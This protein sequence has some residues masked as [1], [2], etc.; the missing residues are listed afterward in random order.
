[1]GKAKGK[2][3]LALLALAFAAILAAVLCMNFP[4][5]EVHAETAVA[6]VTAATGETQTYEK[7][8]DAFKAAK[9]GDT[10]DILQDASE[11][12][13]ADLAYG[14]EAEGG[15]WMYIRDKSLTING[16]GHTLTSNTAAWA[17]YVIDADDTMDTLTINDLTIVSKVQKIQHPNTDLRGA[18]IVLFHG[19]ATLKLNN[20]TLD[21]TATGVGNMAPLRVAGNG[22]NNIINIS[23][24]RLLANKNNGYAMIAFNPVDLTVDN[25]TLSGWSAL[26]MTGTAKGTALGTAG[27][28]VIIQ[29]GSTLTTQSVHNDSSINM[30]G[31]LAFED[32]NITVDIKD[33]KITADCTGNAPQYV[34]Y[35]SNFDKQSRTGIEVN[36]ANTDVAIT[37]EQMN[38]VGGYGAPS[39]KEQDVEVAGGN[40]N[41][42]VNEDY[43]A[44][45]YA[46]NEDGYVL[47]SDMQDA[48]AK[49]EKGDGA[50]SYYNDLQAAFTAAAGGETVKLLVNLYLTETVR[51]E[52]GNNTVFD[53]NG[54]KITVYKDESSGKSLY[55]FD[56]YG[57][58]TLMDSAGTGSITARGIQNLGDGVLTVNSG[59][60]ISCDS[61]GGAAIWNE[62]TAYINGGEF[63]TVFVGTPGDKV[64]IGCLNNSGTA[65]VTGGTFNDVNRR[66]YAII[67]TGKIEITP[68]E[69]KEVTVF[70]AHGALAVDSGTAV[71]NG[72]NYSS[73]EYY[74]LYVSNDGLGE[75]PLEAAVT[76]NGGTFSGK[77]YSVWVGSD[78]N[79]PV[80]STI[81][82]T[83]GVFKKPLNAQD[84]ARDG[85]IA[86]S[87]GTF[88]EA[89]PEEYLAEGI[90][91][92]TDEE[93]NFIADKVENF[94]DAVAMVEETGVAYETLQAAVDAAV[95]G[96]VITV[97]K[98]ITT[99]SALIKNTTKAPLAAEITIDLNGKT[100]TATG[101]GYYLFELIPTTSLTIT[102]SNGNA[103]VVANQAMQIRAYD[104][105]TVDILVENI[106]F[107]GTITGNSAIYLNKYG[108][109]EKQNV[110]LNNVTAV[111][112]NNVGA[113]IKGVVEATGGTHLTV[114]D[115]RIEVT[116]VAAERSRPFIGVYLNNTASTTRGTASSAVIENSTVIANKA[117]G[118][119]EGSQWGVGIG[120]YT[121][122]L[123]VSGGTVT[124]TDGAG[125]TFFGGV[126]IDSAAELLDA[127]N[128]ESFKTLNLEGGVAVSG[129]TFA[130]SGNG[131]STEANSGTVI[132]V[133]SATL[134]GELGVGIYQPQVG[135]LNINAG[136]NIQGS[137]GIEIRA[138]ELNV[139]G[140]NITATWEKL[141]TYP[142]QA[143][144]GTSID[145]A[146]IA[147][148]Q[149]STNKPIFVNIIDGNFTG[150]VALYE[151]DL[152]NEVANEQI[153]ADITGGTFTSTQADMPAVSS[154][155]MD[156]FVLGGKFN[157]ALEAK[158]LA[159]GSVL[160]ATE[161]E[162]G[163]IVYEVQAED[164]Y[165]AVVT[166]GEISIAYATLEEAVNAAPDGSTIELLGDV[167]LTHDIR[168][169]KDEVRNLTFDLGGNTLTSE[170]NI[171][172][173]Y[174]YGGTVTFGNGTIVVTG[175]DGT[176]GYA[177]DVDGMYQAAKLVLES[178]LTVNVQT[179]G[180]HDSAVTVWGPNATLVTSA[181]LTSTGNEGTITGNGTYSGTT[182]EI[183]GGKVINKVNTA[184]YHPQNGTLTV[185]DAYIEGVTGI[186]MRAGELTVSGNAE[187]VATGEFSV[188]ANPSGGTLT[189]VAIGISQ[190]STNLPITVNLEGGTYTSEN[191]Y[192]LYETDVQDPSAGDIAAISITAG[193][194]A[195]KIYSENAEGFIEGTGVTFSEA[196]DYSYF[197]EDV[198]AVAGDEGYVTESGSYTAYIE[199][200]GVRV[201]Y[202]SLQQAVNAIP[203]GNTEPVTVYIVD[204]DG[205]G[206]VEG[207]GVKVG[208][209]SGD[210]KNVI[211][212]FGDL[213]YTVIN[214]TVGS[215]GTETNG[216][217]LLRGSKVVMQ[218]GT[219]KAGTDAAAILIQKYCDLELID[220]TID[221][222]GSN[223]QYAVS[224]NNGTTTFKGETNVYAREGWFAFDVCAWS[225]YGDVAVV[226]DESFTGSVQGKVEYS[227]Y[228]SVPAGWEDKLQITF[229]EGNQGLYDLTFSYGA[230]CDMDSVNI[231]VYD[232][233]FVNAVDAAYLADGLLLTVDEDGNYVVKN[234]DTVAAEGYK[235]VSDNGETRI[236]YE[237]IAEALAAADGTEATITLLDNV[238]EN[239]TIAKGQSIVLDLNGYTLTNN[240]NAHTIY[241]QGKL[242]IVGNGTVDNIN[243][244]RAALV[245]YGT[246]ELNGGKFTRSKED[247]SSNSWYVILN[248][249]TMTV[250]EG[251]SVY[252][253]QSA[254][255][256]SSLLVNGLEGNS[257][258][259]LPSGKD[260]AF[261]T[262]NGG[263]FMGGVAAIKNDYYGILD[264]TGGT[265][266]GSSTDTALQNWGEA[267]ITGDAVFEQDVMAYTQGSSY[268]K[269]NTSISGGTFLGEI[270]SRVY[271]D[272]SSEN[273][274]VVYDKDNVAVS[275]GTF[276]E[277]VPAAYL[278]DGF[279]LTVGDGTYGVEEADELATVTRG[280]AVYN[281][282]TLAEALAFAEDG[283]TVTLL[284]GGGISEAL[285]IDKDIT[286]DLNGVT[287]YVNG[288]QGIVITADGVTVT[289]GGGSIIASME[290]RT[291]V[292]IDG[293]KDVLLENVT[294]E[295]NVVA[296]GAENG[297]DVTLQNST[298]D[299]KVLTNSGSANAI[300]I[301][302][303]DME[304]IDSV[305][306][307]VAEPTTLTGTVCTAI[308]IEGTYGSDR[309]AAAAADPATYSHLKISGNNTKITARAYAIVGNG[310]LHGTDIDI[311]GGTIESTN[312]IAIYHPQVGELTISG[313]T[314]IK[315][316]S[317]L[318]MRAGSLV[319]EGDGVSVTATDPFM[320]SPLSDGFRFAGVAV[321][322]SRYF[323]EEETG[324]SVSIEGGTFT[325]TNEEG[326]AFYEK[327]DE[328]HAPAVT[329]DNQDN[330]S[331]SIAG[332]TFEGKVESTNVTGFI[333]GGMFKYRPAEDYMNPDFVAELQ[334]GYYVPVESSALRA[335]Q[336]NAQADVREY[337]AMLG[338]KWA[339]VLELEGEGDEN[340]VALVAAYN[341]IA[342]T[343]SEKGV[344]KARLDA[345]DAA[346]TLA[347]AQEDWE[348]A[349]ADKIAELESW[350]DENANG[351]VIPL[352]IYTA[353]NSAADEEEL[354]SYFE[355]AKAE[356]GDIYAYRNQITAQ[357]EDL[358]T[359]K[360]TLTALNGALTG[361]NN[362]F[363][364]LLANV[365]EAIGKAQSAIIGTDAD[366]D[367]L[368]GIRDYLEKT[369]NAALEGIDDAVSGTNGIASELAG[370]SD[371]LNGFTSKLDTITGALD[372][373]TGW[374]ADAI[375]KAQGDI[376]SIL[377]ALDSLADGTD[378][379]ALAD[380]LAQILEDIAA[381]QGTVD[382]IEGEVSA[383]SS[384]QE[385]KDEALTDIEEWL[386]NYLDSI[387]GGTDEANGGALVALAFTAET[388]DGDIYAKLTKVFSEDNAQLVLRYYNEALASIDAATT[389]S[390]VTTAVSTFKA[391][392]ASV[393]AAAQNTT[394]LTGLY[395]LLVIVLVAVVV[396]LVIVIVKKNRLA[397]AAEQ[398]A[399]EAEQPVPAEEVPA[400]EPEQPEPAAEENELA[401]EA[402]DDKEQVVIAANVR[403]FSEAYVE[404]NEELLDLFNKV[405]EY[406]LAK[407][408][409]AE[410]KQSNGICIKRNGKQ[411]VKLTVRRG[412]PVALFFLENEMLK[413]FRRTTNTNAK[414]KI[415]ATELVLREAADLEAA[416]TMVDLSVEQIDKDI[417]NAKERRRE[418]RR[419]R[420][421]QKQLE[422]EA[423]QQEIAAGSAE[424]GENERP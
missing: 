385:A 168:L 98:D 2:W 101:S 153:E 162:D 62:A 351:L 196:V 395:V 44:P 238:N 224:N 398:P 53:L 54:K 422:E 180:V 11:N 28:E 402:D 340:A 30:F 247:G 362:S 31:V 156:S 84:V 349:K 399:E 61:N 17:M 322:V 318:E 123:T 389:V 177:F 343:T 387:I 4:M 404:L 163:E 199:Q 249:G 170:S 39:I 71:V 183:A 29:N 225:S 244:G 12:S 262:V 347:A 104:A 121:Y 274:P 213:T 377:T 406:A 91:Q 420:R 275:G 76:V 378:I 287:L 405:K 418:A 408:G 229:A 228:G 300:E 152:L 268:T 72:G 137:S 241:N 242:T 117:A 96:D 223:V 38:F 130:V 148:S 217:Q 102:S 305:V 161:N 353:M 113:A 193:D 230:G 372:E 396:V 233:A 138:G 59:K 81:A 277:P 41:F 222:R 19:Y 321:G 22:D 195:G 256:R 286:F 363:D 227:Y 276:T 367:S 181:S 254:S 8:S 58:F 69:G 339:E 348:Q 150:P 110:T 114:K 338:M 388:T 288:A 202:A 207:G 171:G 67:S 200:D 14:Y 5:A 330:L 206:I 382:E 56:N 245:N 49:I 383:V 392:V 341:A 100:I 116:N 298:V 89:V 178:D 324:V 83:G 6:K 187:I 48:V 133:G 257:S 370:I 173:F 280:E 166:D 45:G 216:F 159:D 251:V 258:Y 65:F 317:G 135:I 107:S 94:E 197:A 295:A 134:K 87:G 164:E 283:D 169:N 419:A 391:Q 74:G 111:Y 151:E 85:A 50:V 93:G 355:Q 390:E 401:A 82:I 122:D 359:L 302:C 147:I 373:E 126:M 313:N 119:E 211:I 397:E 186:E 327:V 143:G 226:F 293:A 354:N 271:V 421:K 269:G 332:G 205:D 308:F 294:I 290:T 360:D 412:Y 329:P 172:A 237:T 55:A 157:T 35:Y 203:N 407:D 246:A 265:F 380:S 141:Q 124:S 278:E 43:Y 68:A 337:V 243:H 281:F 352:Y 253:A 260:N 73:S 417:E 209:E 188:G 374:I 379:E 319:I 366:S 415:R 36:F 214:P 316:C 136:A 212:D 105:S 146:A 70:G 10:I 37:G 310:T 131:S 414:L 79:D 272:G 132:N 57:A 219:L 416:Y 189:G 333:S 273:D 369:I 289:G 149:H 376:T 365:E 314:Q 371:V 86:V 80:N 15:V 361:E 191:G 235:V 413:D 267:T 296:V 240:G 239:V 346:D 21:S 282:A 358:Q 99:S 106:D 60:I 90:A 192:A 299:V 40:F 311:L 208:S 32:N 109:V 336:K 285:T 328:E 118:S 129:Y 139:T 1:M 179:S 182:I 356:I 292:Y 128:T 403:S 64:G 9:D 368:A 51:V 18:P 174:I 210:T 252:A 47:P 400:A 231:T 142:K 97:L 27:S 381:V 175:T 232:G 291:A 23:D 410:V 63:T 270:S 167:T 236:A 393:E 42:D 320:E 78:Y 92:M 95:D 326:Y 120:A 33:S 145:G 266:G 3:L 194:F 303:S 255:L 331:V 284:E 279:T 25:S 315:G 204:V 409:A 127:G 344:A 323:A 335:A 218:N 345:M 312:S 248:Q 77:S 261:L 112:D 364:E 264:V 350:R 125:I 304:I 46:Q 13:E 250:N 375:E 108:A 334:N 66:T 220:M 88:S 301:I 221:V 190:H 198:I 34:V 7:L 342:D 185:K 103:T 160:V 234:Q 144:S 158:D 176:S 307:C 423:Q 394:N 297:A 411:I 24:S 357:S 306:T 115:S 140:G 16:N 184:V 215:S 325:A 309:E 263:S 26:Y 165:E 201:G 386:N 52:A 75:D 259:P 154:E 155:N 384:V 424:N 20:V